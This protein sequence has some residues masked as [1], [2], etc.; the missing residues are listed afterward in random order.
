MKIE[1]LPPEMDPLIWLRG[2][3]SYL[4]KEE[5]SKE[6]LDRLN[7]IL[8]EFYAR[9]TKNRVKAWTT[10][11]MKARLMHDVHAKDCIAIMIN[12][13]EIRFS[14]RAPNENLVELTEK[15]FFK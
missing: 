4:Q 3:L 2:E 6:N 7:A 15:V 10:S 13:E 8:R 5:T 12:S 1:P 14:N 9:L 11:E